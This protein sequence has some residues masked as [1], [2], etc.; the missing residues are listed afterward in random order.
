MSKPKKEAFYNILTRALRNLNFEFTTVNSSYVSVTNGM[1]NGCTFKP[2]GN[3]VSVVKT[4]NDWDKVHI[5]LDIEVNYSFETF[6]YKLFK[7]HIINETIYSKILK[8]LQNG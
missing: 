3:R 1:L 8:S 2:N 4:R 5:S 7:F 6:L